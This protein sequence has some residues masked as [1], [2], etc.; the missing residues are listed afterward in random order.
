MKKTESIVTIIILISLFIMA[1]M[2]DVYHVYGF[3]GSV[4]GGILGIVAAF[5]MF[6]PAI[7]MLIKRMAPV[8]KLIMKVIPMS[9]LLTIHIYGTLF[10]AVLAF[11]HSGNMEK[12]FYGQALILLMLIILGSGYTGRYLMRFLL[13]DIKEQKVIL[14][15][16]NMEYKKYA[17]GV[18]QTLP[19]TLTVS[20]PK[21]I[22]AMADLEF[23]IYAQ[24]HVK[25]LFSRWLG[26]HIGLTM[27][28]YAI[29][30]LHIWTGI[31]YGI[32]WYA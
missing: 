20:L 8:R 25:K 16:M 15:R 5:F 29:L 12:T 2:G 4:L 10:A 27:V 1:Y 9:T 21:I 26:F 28:F 19:P 7:Y 30:V 3:G 6:F 14:K 23:S 13:E 31:Y 18:R 17:G 24:D 32:R 22:F 11:V